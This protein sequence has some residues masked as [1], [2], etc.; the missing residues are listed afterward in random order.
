MSGT[1]GVKGVFI[2]FGSIP[3]QDLERIAKLLGRDGVFATHELPQHFGATMVAGDRESLEQLKKK[4]N[5][6]PTL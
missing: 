3:V 4:M 6:E 5:E 1:N 2:A